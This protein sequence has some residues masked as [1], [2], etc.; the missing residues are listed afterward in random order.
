[1]KK[2][3]IIFLILLC[4]NVL[5]ADFCENFEEYRR[6][7]KRNLH[8]DTASTAISDTT[9]NQF[10]RQGVIK[11]MPLIQAIKSTDLFVTVHRQG[12]YTLDS[13][14]VG[15]L[16]VE[17][18]KNDSLKSLLYSPKEI[19]HEKELKTLAGERSYDGRPSFY[20]YIDNTIY[21]YPV[22]FRNG[23][24]IR[25]SVYRKI[26]SIS[27]LDSLILIPQKYRVAVLEYAT[28]ISARTVQH[29]LMETFERDFNMSVSILK[30]GGANVTTSGK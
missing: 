20:D 7:I 23:D 26:N 13:T 19:W 17:W 8:L 25:V 11:V 29:P 15:V 18:S 14:V 9:L 21:L 2:L 30:S 10:I 12:V 24:S 28:W 27:A 3:I 6:Q 16:N 1:M 4:G 22:P 5:S